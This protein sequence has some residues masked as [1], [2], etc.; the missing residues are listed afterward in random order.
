M[1]ISIALCTY[2]GEKF[3]RDQINSFINQT[4]IPN[5][6]V[7]CDDKSTDKTLEILN[8]FK[9]EHLNIHFEILSNTSTLG[10]VKNFEK[11]ISNCSGDIILLSDQDDL[12][13]DN[14]IEKI[15]N[16][17]IIET[18][19]DVVFTNG[20]LMGNKEGTLW[21]Y[22]KFKSNRQKFWNNHGAL[23]SFLKYKSICTGASMAIR[24]RAFSYILPINNDSNV[25]HDCW[26][27]INAAYQNR[28]GFLPDKLFYYRIHSE[29]WTQKDLI[30][31]KN[32]RI[33]FLQKKVEFILFFTNYFKLNS[34]PYTTLRNHYTLR[35][36]LPKSFLKRFYIVIK[37]LFKG[38]Y[39]KFSPNIKTA[40]RDI[41]KY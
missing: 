28:I 4:I 29:Q 26:I 24:K 23:L 38:N 25:L 30:N 13:V 15:V 12:W 3:I 41:I 36:N 17:F 35:V 14:K 32:S 31:N 33:Q 6:I 11:A 27:G 5:E 40:L 19:I 16:Y 1:K 20:Y 39:S 21:D 34:P 10:V 8:E 9:K 37:E 22:A 7:V 2:N 18:E